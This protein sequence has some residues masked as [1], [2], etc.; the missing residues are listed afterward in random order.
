MSSFANILNYAGASEEDKGGKKRKRQIAVAA[1]LE[2]LKGEHSELVK[3]FSLDKNVIRS[4]ADQ[5]EE[6]LKV[7]DE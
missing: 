1:A 7:Q 2:L 6:A 5:I 3:K 4:T